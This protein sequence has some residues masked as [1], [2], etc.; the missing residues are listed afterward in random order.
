M[1]LRRG[2]AQRV[3]LLPTGAWIRSTRRCAPM[4]RRE[5]AGWP[6]RGGSRRRAAHRVVD[7]FD[8]CLVGQAGD[9]H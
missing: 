2:G 6:C 8:D 5:L 9:G 3:R 1:R 4:R 7:Q